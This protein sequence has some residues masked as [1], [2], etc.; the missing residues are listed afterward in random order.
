TRIG[1]GN[2]ST[3]PFNE[4]ER[5]INGPPVPNWTSSTATGGTTTGVTISATQDSAKGNPAGSLKASMKTGSGN[6]NYL[7]Y[8]WWN[9]SFYYKPNSTQYA[10]TN[11]SVDYNITVGS[12]L[13]QTVYLRVVKP[14]GAVVTLASNISNANTGWR[15]LSNNSF[16]SALNED[17][18][19]TPY[20]LQLYTEFIGAK[21]SLTYTVNY[22]NI[23]LKFKEKVWNRY[24]IVINTTGVPVNGSSKLG[25][26]YQVHQENT[27]LFI[28]NKTSLAYE[29]LETLD[30]GVFFDY[31]KDIKSTHHINS[32]DGVT[33]NVN[34]KFVDD[35]KSDTD[36]VSDKLHIRYLY[37]YTDR[38]LQYSC[39]QCHSPNKHYLN[40]SIG[41][42]D[43][44]KGNNKYNTTD[45]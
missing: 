28:Y 11:A 5:R 29:L 44:F 23:L 31:V 20:K 22:D 39:E 35:D 18:S 33:G 42:P 12:L 25:M 43:T 40:P 17:G 32:S 4:N 13:N 15:N 6:G 34:V 24:E 1:S 45:L 16:A 41:S 9:Y 10:Y 7:G 2:G 38:G 21:T 36:S 19:V 27:S 26:S 3:V 14:S 8:V 37:V 30:K